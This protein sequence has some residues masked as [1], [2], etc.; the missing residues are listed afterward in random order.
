M[1][2]LLYPDSNDEEEM[3]E[4]KLFMSNIRQYN[5]LFAF[6]SIHTKLQFPDNNS[7][8]T[9]YS[10]GRGFVYK[11]QGGMYY[12]VPPLNFSEKRERET[13]QF[14]ILDSDEAKK[15]RLKITGNSLNERVRYLI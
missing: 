14:Y 9:N 4:H 13:A 5:S 6:A 8:S 7:R 15:E 3:E 2:Q 1:R 12:R 10:R 11:I